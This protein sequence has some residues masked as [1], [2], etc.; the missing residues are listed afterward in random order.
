[1]WNAVSIISSLTN[2]PPGRNQQHNNVHNIKF[3]QQTILMPDLH[4]ATAGYCVKLQQAHTI[5][6]MHLERACGCISCHRPC[7]Q[8]SAAMTF[9]QAHNRVRHVKEMFHVLYSFT[10]A[11]LVLCDEGGRLLRDLNQIS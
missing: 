1:M 10:M 3:A 5:G 6:K 4:G 7:D 2:A 8:P 11:F 9:S